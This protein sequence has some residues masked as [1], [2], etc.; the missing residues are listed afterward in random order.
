MSPCCRCVRFISTCFILLAFALNTLGVVKEPQNDT[1]SKDNDFL[2]EEYLLKLMDKLNN[3]ENEINHLENQILPRPS[4]QPET[5]NKLKVMQIDKF[6]DNLD[7]GRN[8]SNSAVVTSNL[9]GV[10]HREKIFSLKV[11]K[12]DRHLPSIQRQQS[13]M[14]CIGPA[15]SKGILSRRHHPFPFEVD[16][17]SENLEG[18]IA[19]ED[20]LAGIESD[21]FGGCKQRICLIH[22]ACLTNVDSAITIF[23]R[24]NE[25]KLEPYFLKAD[26]D[27]ALG[28]RFVRL[29]T[30]RS[31]KIAAVPFVVLK[32]LIS[33]ICFVIL[34][35][36]ILFP[37]AKV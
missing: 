16:P 6:T 30:H 5:N 34:F 12:E 36:T 11:S 18:V 8:N 1:I 28:G 9:Q 10:F 3:L 22:N 29:D 26:V 21:N 7:I 4:S 24:T 15:S 19:E 33:E 17:F 13:A 23:L 27:E 20:L 32:V 35:C 2:A 25:K 37:L 31:S 14:I